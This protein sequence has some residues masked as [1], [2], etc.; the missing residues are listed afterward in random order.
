MEED[1]GLGAIMLVPCVFVFVAS[2]W[3]VVDV[4]V[5]AMRTRKG[6]GPV[7]RGGERRS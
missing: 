5:M 6:R 4:F 3:R 7:W 2:E 1:G